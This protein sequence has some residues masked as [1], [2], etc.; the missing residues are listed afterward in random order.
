MRR[1]EA[2]ERRDERDAARR[3]DRERQSLALRGVR[4]NAEPVPQPLDRGAAGQDRAL[5]RVA[6]RGGRRLEQPEG[7]RPALGPRVGEHEAAGAVCRLCLAAVEAAVAEE[8]RLLV[9]GD[10]RD[11]ERH[12]KQ[13]GL[14]DDLRGAD[15]P[16][17][18]QRVDAEQVEQLGRPVERVQV[19]EHRPGRVRQVGGVLAA[20]GQLP[21]EPRVDRPERELRAAAAS[22]RASSHS[23]FVAEK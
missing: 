22:V 14:A 11:R 20:A 10:P 9:A 13:L 6:A 17:Q 1:A 23:S 15:E 3:L 2:G 4:E 7:R 16:G 5:E 8:G 18:Q 12:A 19:E 21:D